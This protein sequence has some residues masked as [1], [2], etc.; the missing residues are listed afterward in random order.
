MGPGVSSSWTL[1]W[2]V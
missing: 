2:S 1:P